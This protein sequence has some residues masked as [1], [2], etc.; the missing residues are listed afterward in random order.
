M[1]PFGPNLRAWRK[2]RGLSQEELGYSV[3]VSQTAI[4]SW[5]RGS[6]PSR[7]HLA[8]LAAVTGLP[9]GDMARRLR[10]RAPKPQPSPKPSP[11]IPRRQARELDALVRTWRARR[12]D[13]INRCRHN[14]QW[15]TT[16]RAKTTERADIW[17]Q[18]AR[19]LEAALRAAEEAVAA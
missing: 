15:G 14:P 8:A 1:T 19:E 3:G 5:E 18:A 13:L 17:G 12:E 2:Q 4:S 9:L 11:G 7:R 6:K 16:H 10:G